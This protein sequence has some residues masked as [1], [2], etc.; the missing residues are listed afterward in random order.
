METC[1]LH[2]YLSIQKLV[3][4]NKKVVQGFVSFQGFVPLLYSVCEIENNPSLEVI[5]VGES[6]KSSYNF[7][8]ADLELRGDC[9]DRRMMNRFAEIENNCVWHGY[10]Q[11]LFS[12]RV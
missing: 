2:K 10:I 7:L 8:Y 1:F 12:C 9:N 5:E 3:K 4:T 6:C 11:V